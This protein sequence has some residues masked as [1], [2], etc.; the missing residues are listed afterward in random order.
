L[1]ASNRGEDS[2]QADNATSAGRDSNRRVQIV[3]QKVS[4]QAP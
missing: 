3:V 4:T 2:P 1:V